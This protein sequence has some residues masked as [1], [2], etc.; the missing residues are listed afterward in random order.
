MSSFA[1]ETGNVRAGS[2]IS[3]HPVVGNCEDKLLPLL[4]VL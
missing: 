3:L 2:Q 4:H 1:V